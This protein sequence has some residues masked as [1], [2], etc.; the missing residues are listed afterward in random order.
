LQEAYLAA[1]RAACRVLDKTEGH[2][3]YRED[4]AD[5]L[6]LPQGYSL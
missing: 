4:A 3:A 1:C 2:C 5:T 6:N